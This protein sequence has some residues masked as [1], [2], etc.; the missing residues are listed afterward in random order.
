MKR[1]MRIVRNQNIPGDSNRWPTQFALWHQTAGFAFKKPFYG[2]VYLI[3]TRYWIT[4][5]N[6]PSPYFA[7]RE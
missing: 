2:H 7:I 3:A 5:S 4:S 1:V 6:T